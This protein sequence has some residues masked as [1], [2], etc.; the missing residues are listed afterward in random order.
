[1]S[2]ISV[3]VLW[4][5]AEAVAGSEGEGLRGMWKGRQPDPAGDGPPTLWRQFPLKGREEPGLSAWAFLPTG[6][7]Q[8][9]GRVYEEGVAEGTG[10]EDLLENIQ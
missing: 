7:Q 4:P 5:T 6:K 1:M 8:F 2:L 10:Q 3:S 9:V